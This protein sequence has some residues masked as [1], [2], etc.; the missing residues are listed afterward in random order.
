MA[1]TIIKNLISNQ[2]YPSANPISVSIDSNNSGKC[3]FRYICDIWINGQKATT[4]K[5]FPDPVTGYGLFEISRVLGDYI[6]TYENLT[7]FTNLL[8][9]AQQVALPTSAFK[10]QLKF[11]EEYDLTQTCDG[12]ILQYA[13]L[14]TSNTA[15]VFESAVDFFDYPTF[16]PGQFIVGT[17]SATA[18]FLTN[19]PRDID[20]TYNDGYYVDF[21][22]LQT[23]NVANWRVDIKTFDASG[24]GVGT[25]SFAAAKTHTNIFRFR[26]ACGPL[27]INS[28]SATTT[29]NKQ[30]SYYTMQLRYVPT[31][32]YVTEIFTFRLKEPTTFRHRFGFTGQGG[33]PESFTFFHRLRKTLDIQKGL[34]NKSFD[35]SYGGT[36]QYNLGGRGTDIFSIR[37]TETAQVSTFVKEQFSRFLTELYL[38]KSVWFLLRPELIPFRSINDGGVNKLVIFDFENAVGLAKDTPINKLSVGD[39]IYVYADNSNYN[40]RF[41]ITNISSGILTTSATWSA[42]PNT[43][44]WLHKSTAWRKAPIIINNS[45]VEIQQRLGRPIQYTMDFAFSNTKNLLK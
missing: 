39:L 23:I 2:F 1:I 35:L 34:Y 9:A 24:L 45:S 8:D 31:G 37:A 27:D 25:H 13:N 21:L 36:P 5:L 14:A 18:S 26:I 30:I 20:I 17:T 38:S 6:S 28:V 40:G 4:L 12:A 16:T 43:C 41:S 3:N 42:L 33:A 11:G 22:T 19:S 10:I 29:I 15:Y 7:N 44:G 32:A